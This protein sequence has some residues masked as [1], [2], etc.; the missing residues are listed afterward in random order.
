MTGHSFP[1]RLVRT[2]TLA[3]LTDKAAHDGLVL[4]VRL[5][6]AQFVQQE[7]E[8]RARELTDDVQVHILRRGLA[9]RHLTAIDTDQLPPEA[10][11]QIRFACEALI[12]G[13]EEVTE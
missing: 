5:A 10:A 3:G 11:E 6:G 2:R 13:G 1:F 4:A 7:A 12:R 8:Q 9:L